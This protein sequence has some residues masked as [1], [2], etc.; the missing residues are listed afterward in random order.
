MRSTSV[1]F[2]KAE[3]LAHG[4]VQAVTARKPMTRADIARKL[5]ISEAYAH[6]RAPQTKAYKAVMKQAGL[7]IEERNKGA[8]EKM[9]NIRDTALDKTG[10]ALQGSVELRDAV[11]TVDTINKNIQM[12]TGGR[13]GDTPQPIIQILNY[14]AIQDGDNVK[15]A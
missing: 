2:S 10:Q 15:E 14:V 9:L 12:L 8:V 7:S 6:V 13:T 11:N 3:Q 4:M 1:S 5:G